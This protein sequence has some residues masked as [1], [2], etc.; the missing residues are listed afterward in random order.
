MQPGV[1]SRFG[2]ANTKG[3]VGGSLTSSSLSLGKLSNSLA[4]KKVQGSFASSSTSNS[5][6]E[7]DGDDEKPRY[8]ATFLKLNNNSLSSLTG[9]IDV[10]PQILVDYTKLAWVDLSSNLLEH[11]PTVCPP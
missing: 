6:D 5:V 7:K 4:N 11:I 3:D 1:K 10:V 8:I 9:F 2:D